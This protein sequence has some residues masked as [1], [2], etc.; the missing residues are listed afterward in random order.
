M[1]TRMLELTVKGDKK[2]ELFNR[3]K[4]DILPI[5]NKQKGF[6]EILAL[7]SHVE[8][9]KV[10]FLSFWHTT[11]DAE[12]YQDETFPKVKKVFEPFLNAAPIVKVFT[13]EETLS[14]KFTHLMAA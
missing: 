4:V 7:E 14:E 13:V 9:N 1:Y 6:V 10:M 11:L 3:I 2:T 5:L 12:R 8:L